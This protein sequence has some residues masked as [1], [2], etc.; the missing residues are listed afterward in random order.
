MS[1]IRAAQVN[2]VHIYDML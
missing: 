2:G 1:E